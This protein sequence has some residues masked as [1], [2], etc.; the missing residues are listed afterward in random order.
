M[1]AYSLALIQT[2]EKDISEINKTIAAHQKII[3]D[4]QRDK[5][6]IEKAIRALQSAAPKGKSLKR[7]SQ[8]SEQT[9][10]AAMISLFVTNGNAPT[11]RK[12][13]AEKVT[14]GNLNIVSQQ[15]SIH[16]EFQS[17]GFGF[18]NLRPDFYAKIKAK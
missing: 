15:L 1:I 3:S 16:P 2:A 8:K 17:D 4:L 11:H 10:R 5:A 14:G 12:V 7:K 18:W 13:I 9:R 6:G